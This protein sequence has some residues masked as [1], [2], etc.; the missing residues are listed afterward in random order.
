MFH[1]AAPFIDGVFL[2][3]VIVSLVIGVAHAIAGRVRN[4]IGLRETERSEGGANDRRQFLVF[5]AKYG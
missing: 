5:R 4:Q 2:E 1:G 3:V